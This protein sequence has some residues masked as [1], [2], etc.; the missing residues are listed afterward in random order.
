[1]N[2]TVG[3]ASDAT[4]APTPSAAPPRRRFRSASWLIGIALI[5]LAGWSASHAGASLPAVWGTVT[6]APPAR[7]ALLIALITLTPA[8][9]SL[10]FWL[11]QRRYTRLGYPENTA[12][13]TS[14]WLLNFLPLAPGLVGRLAYLKAVHATPITHSARAVIWA[15]ILSVLGAVTLLLTVALGAAASATNQT[16]LALLAAA[17]A[18]PLAALAWYAHIKKPQ[19]DPEV[20]RVVAALTVRYAELHLWA[21]R[22]WMLFEIMNTPI[23]WG[24]ALAIAAV[25][26][27]ASL[28]PL[29]PNGLGLREWAVGLVAPLL[30]ASLAYTV[31]LTAAA[32][33]SADLVH[34]ACEVLVAVPTGLVATLWVGARLRQALQREPR[35]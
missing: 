29:A 16:A 32:G 8:L 13:I 4:A 23:A 25:A 15:N 26:G 14:A 35:A 3:P 2:P 31:G 17:P 33:L 19:P 18:I 27:L 12:L 7:L 24:G 10:M 20:W 6:A 30:P 21:A 11:L 5:A 9:T 22:Y 34:R 1:M 28:F